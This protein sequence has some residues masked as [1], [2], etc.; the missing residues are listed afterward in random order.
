[1]EK[2]LYRVEDAARA[3]SL[4]RTQVYA[5]IRAGEL[6]SVKI[7]SSRRIPVSALQKFLAGLRRELATDGREAQSEAE[8]AFQHLSGVRWLVARLRDHGCEA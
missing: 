2:L 5:L 4:G 8:R 3:L 6:E 7:G 1:M